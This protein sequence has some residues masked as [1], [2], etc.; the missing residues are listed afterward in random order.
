MV[1]FIDCH[2]IIAASENRLTIHPEEKVVRILIICAAI[3][4]NNESVVQVNHAIALRQDNFAICPGYSI[5][6]ICSGN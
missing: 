1:F 5:G 4:R 3:F 2:M 6:S